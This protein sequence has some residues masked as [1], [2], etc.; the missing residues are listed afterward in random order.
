MDEVFLRLVRL[1]TLDLLV[2]YSQLDNRAFEG[3]QLCIILLSS[4]LN[5]G[6]HLESSEL[7]ASA[8]LCSDS[9]HLTQ[10]AFLFDALPKPERSENST[11][12]ERCI[13]TTDAGI[14]ATPKE[15]NTTAKMFAHLQRGHFCCGCVHLDGQVHRDDKR[16]DPSRGH[17]TQQ[18]C[19]RFSLQINDRLSDQL[20]STDGIMKEL[21]RGG[22]HS[23]LYGDNLSSVK[24]GCAEDPF[25]LVETDGIMKE[26]LRGGVHS[27]LYGDNLSSVKVGCAEDPFLLVEMEPAYGNV[28]HIRTQPDPGG[29][30]PQQQQQQQTLQGGSAATLDA[31]QRSQNAEGGNAEGGVKVRPRP[32]VPPKPQMD[33]VRYSMANVQESCDWELDTLLNEL[34]ALESQLNSTAGGD[35]LLLGLPTLPV[36]SSKSNSANLS[37]RN[38]TLSAATTQHAHID[39]HNKRYV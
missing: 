15:Q 32:Q 8:S 23:R 19:P 30:H 35:Q 28:R 25:L 9:V 1:S 34:S 4:L 18:L 10:E 22:V 26:L 5:S 3:H 36:S 37:Q 17:M 27:R 38:S 24:V 39:S 33:A 29:L 12:T 13:A 20:L 6:P 11:E 21:L 2:V 7:C 14:V 31:Q 16:P